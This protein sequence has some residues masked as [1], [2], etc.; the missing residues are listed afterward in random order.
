MTVKVIEANPGLEGL[1]RLTA[2][3][4][5]KQVDGVTLTMDVLTPQMAETPESMAS[6][7]RFPLVVFVQGSAW[8]TPDRGYEIP[9]LSQLARRGFVVASVGHRDA[10]QGHPFPAFL[11][12]VKSAIRFLRAHAARFHAD[13]DRVGIWGT[14]SGGNTALLVALTAGDARYDDGLNPGVS[15]GV[16]WTVACFPP[17]DIPELIATSPLN[18]TDAD[19]EYVPEE[20]R[21]KDARHTNAMACVLGVD[22]H[23][24]PAEYAEAARAMSPCLIA[25]AGRNLGP[26]LLL[27]GDADTLVPFDQSVRMDDRL[28]D[29]GYDSRLVRV[30]GAEHESTFWSQ[31]VL[32]EIFR[33]IEGVEGGR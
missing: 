12:D 20:Q 23:A 2:N 11:E 3:V 33:F 18:V 13:P 15:D 22:L 4:P 1:A 25:R 7:R 17:T 24:D 21:A 30:H 31:T 19:D 28:R 6:D 27:H 5:Y 10:K 9:Q 32:D 8:T 26:F 16:G 29:L 14:S